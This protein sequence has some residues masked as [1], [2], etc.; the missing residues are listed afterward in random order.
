MNNNAL[1]SIALNSN[2]ENIERTLMFLNWVQSSQ[3]NYDLLIYGILGKHYLLKDGLIFMP[4]GMEEDK[5]PYYGWFSLPFRNA[6][7]DREWAD[8][9]DPVNKSEDITSFLKKYT[10]YAPHEG[11]YPDYKD[12]Q[13]L[14]DT[15]VQLFGN[16][17]GS[18]L[19]HGAFDMEKADSIIEE[20]NK[21]GT[22]QIVYE[23]Q[24]QLDNWKALNE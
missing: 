7:L 18:R 5:N 6:N 19:E 14:C 9:Y 8:E 13:A 16:K 23:A 15:R 4:E 11:F 24:K 20:I 12:I 2:S 3:E 17:I 1:C 22:D 10:S 21:A